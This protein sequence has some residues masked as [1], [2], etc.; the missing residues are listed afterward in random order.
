MRAGSARSFLIEKDDR[1]TVTRH[2]RF[3]KHQ[4]KTNNL[5]C[6]GQTLFLLN[7]VVLT[8]HLMVLM[9][10]PAMN[11]LTITVFRRQEFSLKLAFTP[12]IHISF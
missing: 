8:E 12:G 10:Y 4:W 3:F 7:L 2:S 9:M 6:L 11:E 5:T 1:N